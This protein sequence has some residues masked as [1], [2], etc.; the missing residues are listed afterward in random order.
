MGAAFHVTRSMWKACDEVPA[1]VGGDAAD[2]EMISQRAVVAAVVLCRCRCARGQQRADDN[3]HLVGHRAE[4]RWKKRREWRQFHNHRG[5]LPRATTTTATQRKNVVLLHDDDHLLLLPLAGSNHR[6]RG[7]SSMIVPRPRRI[8]TY[9]TITAVIVDCSS[10]VL[11][12][13]RAP[14]PRPRTHTVSWQSMRAKVGWTVAK[15][16]QEEKATMY[17]LRVSPSNAGGPPPRV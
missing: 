14:T 5:L 7:Q 8:C 2:D 16:D 9:S 6:S 10:S 3:L 11:S 17:A 13:V 12:Y 4:M 15:I 1:G